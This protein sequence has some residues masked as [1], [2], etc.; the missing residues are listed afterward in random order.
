MTECRFREIQ[1]IMR[2]PLPPIC[3]ARTLPHSYRWAGV[4]IDRPISER[5]Q[6][7]GQTPDDE[8]DTV[9]ASKVWYSD[10][11]MWAMYAELARVERED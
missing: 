5:G 11:T 6:R 4:H 9:G 10:R 2:A 7:V 1:R 3:A 8:N